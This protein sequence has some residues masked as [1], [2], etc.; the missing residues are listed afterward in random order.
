MEH[1]FKLIDHDKSILLAYIL[2]DPD[3]NSNQYRVE[4]YEVPTIAG[5]IHYLAISG[6][7]GHIHL[8]S[9]KEAELFKQK[10]NIILVPSQEHAVAEVQ[11]W[12][13]GQLG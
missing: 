7:H 9:D 12:L 11:E 3:K 1:D 13:D 10:E 6:S 8:I 4:L 2:T 5:P